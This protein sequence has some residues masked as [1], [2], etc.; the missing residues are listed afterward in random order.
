[1]SLVRGEIS[2]SLKS[3]LL[4]ALKVMRSMIS[5]MLTASIGQKSII[6]GRNGIQP[7]IFMDCIMN[8]LREALTEI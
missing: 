6:G 3:S 5:G 8:T 1:M 2:I 4:F 7:H